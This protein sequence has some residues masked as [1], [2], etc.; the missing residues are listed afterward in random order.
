M[1]RC[2]ADSERQSYGGEDL[3]ELVGTGRDRARRSPPLARRASDDGWISA[4]YLAR[5]FATVSE[6]LRVTGGRRRQVGCTAGLPSAPEIPF[7][8]RQLRLVP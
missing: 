5:P 7:A 8:P 6:E 2:S 1:P 3:H 4:Y